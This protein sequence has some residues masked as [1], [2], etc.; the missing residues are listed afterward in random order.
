M[1]D[2]E[3]FIDVRSITIEPNE[4][5]ISERLTIHMEFE[6]RVEIQNGRWELKYVV[7]YTGK[8]KIIEC[9]H[10]DN[11]QYTAGPASFTFEIPSIDVSSVKESLLRNV[12]LFMATLV[13]GDRELVQIS[14]VTQ[15]HQQDGRLFRTIFNPLE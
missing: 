8:R 15:V 13:E 11:V 5:E 7:D 10:A 4:C 14:M 6:S 3:E 12:G 2:Q 9:G 1:G